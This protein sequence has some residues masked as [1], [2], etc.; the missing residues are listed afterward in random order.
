MSV[1]CGGL[2]SGGGG[3]GGGDG[4]GGAVFDGDVS[5]ET[6]QAMGEV[7]ESY[8]ESERHERRRLLT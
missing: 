7:M 6:K 5:E 4:G 3:S 8:I 1:S 2:F